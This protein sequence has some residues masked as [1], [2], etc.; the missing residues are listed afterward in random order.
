MAPMK[1]DLT[2]KQQLI[3]DSFVTGKKI[4]EVAAATGYS[5]KD[6]AN[7]KLV[8]IAKGYNAGNGFN[9]TKQIR[10]GSSLAQEMDDE[11]PDSDEP[12]G[13][14]QRCRCELV[15]PCHR[16]LPALAKDLLEDNQSDTN[17]ALTDLRT[18]GIWREGMDGLGQDLVESWQETARVQ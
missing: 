2:P 3:L 11:S 9:L 17:H 7:V 5:Y 14:V 18:V 8:L 13:P 12:Y 16:C 6:V 1:T 15:M 4:T 10:D